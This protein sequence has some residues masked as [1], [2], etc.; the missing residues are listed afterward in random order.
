MKIITTFLGVLAVSYAAS[1]SKAACRNF[2]GVKDFN[3][4]EYFK[5]RWCLT[6]IEKTYGPTGVCQESK[7]EVLNDGTVKHLISSYGQG[8]TPEFLHIECTTN[9]KDI[10]KDGKV[11]LQCKILNPTSETGEGFEM[12]ATVVDTDYVS[13]SLFHVCEDV[14]GE[15]DGGDLLVLGRCNNEPSDNPKVKEAV[16]SLGL[17]LDNFS[18]RKSIKCKQDP[19]F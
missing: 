5:G 14:K 11:V 16:K 1:T 3:A 4:N 18:A 9:T 6:N 15:T 12:N 2:P 17:N 7:S 13:Y 19:D 10:G 8:R